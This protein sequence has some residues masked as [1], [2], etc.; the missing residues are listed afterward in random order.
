MGRPKIWVVPWT[1]SYNG[2]NTVR[3]AKDGDLNNCPIKSFKGQSLTAY[4]KAVE[5][6]KKK[7]TSWGIKADIHAY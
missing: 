5:W 2:Q 7:A 4:K 1:E 3:Y 6:A